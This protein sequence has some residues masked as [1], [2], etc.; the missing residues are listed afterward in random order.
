MTEAAFT[1]M[2]IGTCPAMD[3]GCW[4]GRAPTLANVPPPVAA[5]AAIVVAALTVFDPVLPPPAPVEGVIIGV[6]DT[7]P[8]AM[9]V[10]TLG[11]EIDGADTVGMVGKFGNNGIRL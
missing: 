3:I 1:F 11:I 6:E 10:L 8:P 9:V 2:V 5:A 7:E 4:N